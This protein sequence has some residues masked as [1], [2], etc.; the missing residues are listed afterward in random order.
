MKTKYI[1]ILLLVSA[2]LMGIWGGALKA[3]PV[4]VDLSDLGGSSPYW[5]GSAWSSIDANLIHP[6]KGGIVLAYQ[7]PD[8]AAYPINSGSAT[9]T[10]RP[11]ADPGS[12]I[13]CINAPPPSAP[14]KPQLGNCYY[15]VIF[16][17]IH[18]YYMGNLKAGE[19]I[20]YSVSGLISADP[21][22]FTFDNFDSTSQ[23]ADMVPEAGRKAA[24]LVLVLDKSG[25]MEWSARPFHP[26]CDVYDPP[27]PGCEPARWD[28][29]S[30]AVDQTLAVAKAYAIPS[31]KFAVAL[32]DSSVAAQNRFDF[33]T[34]NPVTVNDFMSKLGMVNPS[35][36]TSIG[37][38]MEA[39]E[40]ELNSGDI[41]ALN[42]VL[43]LFTDG[44]QNESPYLVSNG[45]ELLINPTDNSSVGPGIRE[46]VPGK[47]DVCPFA[48]RADDPSGILGT[49]YL[50][51]IADLRC[52]G[53]TNSVMSFDVTDSDLLSFF[54]DSLNDT[55]IGDKLELADLTSGSLAGTGQEVSK[56]EAFV[57]SGDDIAFTS[58]LSWVSVDGVVSI[59]LIKDGVTFDLSPTFTGAGVPIPSAHVDYGRGYISATLR[60]PFCNRDNQCVAGAGNWTLRVKFFSEVE[61]TLR[62]NLYTITDN[63]SI[64]TEYKISQA[65]RGVGRP[66]SLEVKLTEAGIP[67]T[68][69]PDGSVKAE[70]TRPDAGLG[71]VL[72]LSPSQPTSGPT[73]DVISAAGLKVSAMLADPAQRATI[74]A[75]L[76]N[77]VSQTLTLTEA[78]PGI[79]RANYN[80]ADVEG[81]YKANFYVDAETVKNGRFTRT[82]KGGRYIPV[83][84]DKDAILDTIVITTL[85]D[86]KY[87]GGCYA[88]T[89]QPK[90][91]TGNLLGPGKAGLFNLV[92]FD[93]VLMRPVQDKLDGNYVIKVAYPAG[94]TER[95]TI[96]IYGVEITPEVGPGGVL[97]D[98]IDWI[99]HNLLW[100][101]I[102]LLLLLLLLIW[103]L[104][105]RK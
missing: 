33:S 31:D 86:C 69:L 14:T 61:G 77:S 94:V 46:Y 72:S 26:G 73:G 89:V 96:N 68:D 32:F 65:V 52:G 76:Q 25:S 92:D 91:A 71:N 40:P 62:Y 82:R 12:Q 39:F 64:A 90:D 22:N 79:Y 53:K 104:F 74:L 49:T 58:L 48:L 42:Q 27:P 41:A 24:R 5:E 47:V 43:L 13:N 45:D 10:L 102:L 1:R 21:A 87:P 6:N 8:F 88:I 15:Q 67:V 7:I 93:G 59:E 56:D 60:P 35:G 100:V 50:Q 75:A 99:K 38:G 17:Q 36:S 78:E 63:K 23:P 103:W 85:A 105:F 37:S 101:I 29:L 98:I 18:I 80:N 11:S 97:D 44:D 20:A 54:L 28:I 3:A 66:V 30:R 57:V 4:S 84:P 51:E 9:V 55:L 81:F 19:A 83:M 2:L 95:P 16:N 34:I 70:L